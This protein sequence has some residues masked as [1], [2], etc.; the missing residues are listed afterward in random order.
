M[1]IVV[2]FQTHLT[3]CPPPNTKHHFFKNILAGLL[4]KM[5]REWGRHSPKCK[6]STKSIK[7]WSILCYFQSL[8]KL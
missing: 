4:I 7:N 6:Q 3:F 1:Y 8:L 2:S 5:N